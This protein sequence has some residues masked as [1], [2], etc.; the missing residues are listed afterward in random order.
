[1]IVEKEGGRVKDPSL[2][3]RHLLRASGAGALAAAFAGR[4]MAASADEVRRCAVAVRGDL[5][6]RVSP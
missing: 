2:S 6:A 5:R 3:R 4:G 1:M